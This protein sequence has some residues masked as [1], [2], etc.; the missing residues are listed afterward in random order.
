MLLSSV[1]VTTILEKSAP[2]AIDTFDE[3][4]AEKIVT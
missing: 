1:R 4:L 2:N 3:L